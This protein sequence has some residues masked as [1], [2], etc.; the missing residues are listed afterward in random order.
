MNN[1][2]NNNQ[3]FVNVFAGLFT[4]LYKFS[5]SEILPTTLSYITYEGSLTQPGCQETATWVILNRPMYISNYQVSN[6][7][8]SIAI[9]C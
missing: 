5:L 9:G 2:I 8:N 7:L 6:T 4:D 1:I 3:V